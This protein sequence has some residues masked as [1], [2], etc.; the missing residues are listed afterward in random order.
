MYCVVDTFS[1][2][3]SCNYPVTHFNNQHEKSGY[4]TRLCKLYILL[5][6]HIQVCKLP[7]LL[8]SHIQVCKL[9][10]LLYHQFQPHHTQ[11]VLLI[12]ILRE[13]YVKN[14]QWRKKQGMGREYEGRK[15]EKG[16]KVGE[17]MGK[18]RE[19]N[20]RNRQVID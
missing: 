16:E 8:V 17:P 12:V 7:I 19:G 9:W 14:P 13:N 20:E 1:N 18:V 2:V 15:V 3:N 6:D 10:I 5:Y 4:K 11:K